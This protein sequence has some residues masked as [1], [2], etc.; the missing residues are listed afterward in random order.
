MGKPA[1][2]HNKNFDPDTKK[3][4]GEKYETTKG[5]ETLQNLICRDFEPVRSAT[6]K[7]QEVS[8]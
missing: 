8:N 4:Q 2:I 7:F 5:K 1:M 6:R 3:T